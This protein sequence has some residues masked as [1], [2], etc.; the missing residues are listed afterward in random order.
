MRSGEFRNL[1]DTVIYGSPERA[2]EFRKRAVRGVFNPRLS[3]M[4]EEQADWD[5]PEHAD[6]CTCWACK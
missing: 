6:D 2:D 5:E 3:G 4:K 1:V